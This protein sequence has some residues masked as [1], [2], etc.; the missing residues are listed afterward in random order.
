MS[1][2][3]YYSVDPEAVG[4][5]S[6]E[7]QK[8][9]MN[10]LQ[11]KGHVVHRAA[12]IFSDDPEAFMAD[13]QAQYKTKTKLEVYER[14]VDESDIVIADVSA[15]S[16][17]RMYIIKHALDKPN[18]GLPSTKVL[19]IKAKSKQ[20]RFGS[21]IQDLIDSGRVVYFEYDKIE[22]VIDSWDQL[23]SGKG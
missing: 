17:G 2:T 20:R 7:I 6:P 11:E 14:W 16:E 5:E 18:R 21:I 1:E 10:F 8:K 13:A 3:V 9:L 23:V 12:Y 19:L 15:P 22:Q 4:E